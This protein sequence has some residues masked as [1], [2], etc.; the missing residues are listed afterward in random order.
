MHSVLKR[1]LHTANWL[2]SLL[3]K[4]IDGLFLL[5]LFPFTKKEKSL[6]EPKPKVSLAE[7]LP[8]STA[9][10]HTA[11]SQGVKYILPQDIV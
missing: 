5:F 4:V 3:E 10:S 6:Y 11:E 7:T 2:G 1:L 8:L 9:P